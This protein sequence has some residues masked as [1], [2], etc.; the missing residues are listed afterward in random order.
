[1]AAPILALALL[2]LVQ[3]TVSAPEKEGLIIYCQD[4]SGP[5]TRDGLDLRHQLLV[6]NFWP[7]ELLRH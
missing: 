3:G 6:F 7:Y 5:G 2:A 4:D 1:M